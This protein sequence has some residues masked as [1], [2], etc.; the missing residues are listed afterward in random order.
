MNSNLLSKYQLQYTE[1]CDITD[2]NLEQ[3]AKRV[4]AEKHFWVSRLIETKIAKGKLIKEKK[5]LWND[6]ATKMIESSPVSNITKK[7]LENIDT[8]LLSEINDK[9]QELEYLI[10]YLELLV[11]SVSFIAQDIKNIIDIKRLEES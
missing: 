6:E 2:F 11:K 10:E 9:I 4:P 5:K 8:P 1:F 3:R 7:T